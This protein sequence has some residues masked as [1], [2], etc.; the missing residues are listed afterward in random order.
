V[1]WGFEQPEDLGVTFLADAEDLAPWTAGVPALDDDH[2]HRISTR[3]GGVSLASYRKLASWPEARA[4]FERSAFVRRTW[5]PNVRASTLASFE[6]LAP[7]LDMGW[8]LAKPPGLVELRRVLERTSRRTGVL[9][10]MGSDAPTERAARQ[11]R[12]RG[13]LDPALDRVLAISAMAD[14]DYRTA[15]RL[16]ARG[17]PNASAP[18]QVA[19]WRTLALCLLGEGPSAAAIARLADATRVEIPDA[20][21]WSALRRTCGIAPSPE[22]GR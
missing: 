12:E 18:G 1:A 4:R 7:I 9:W 16:L 20:E 6:V 15:E 8:P 13:L 22:G 19:A 5:P 10:L 14:R 3:V 11:A 21:G 17:Q 2:P